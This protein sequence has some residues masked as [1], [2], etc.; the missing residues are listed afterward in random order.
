MT[1]HS[2]T[3]LGLP[4][5]VSFPSEISLSATLGEFCL[6]CLPGPRS[7]WT[8]IHTKELSAAREPEPFC[9]LVQDDNL[10]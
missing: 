9:V 2:Q 5:L 7:L 6:T 10:V 8:D 3:H 4:R 1:K